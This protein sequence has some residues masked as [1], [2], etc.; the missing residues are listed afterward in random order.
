MISYGATPPSTFK[1]VIWYGISFSQSA[2]KLMSKLVVMSSCLSI[3][4]S[5]T[6]SQSLLSITETE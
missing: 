4:K 5:S 3:I 2:S 1:V 6:T